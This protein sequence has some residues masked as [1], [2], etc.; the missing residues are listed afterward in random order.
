[1]GAILLAGVA[2]NAE[3]PAAAPLTVEYYYKLAPGA[4]KEWLAL[5]KKNHHPILREHM[6]SGLL[7]S[8]KLYERRYHSL[9]PAWDYK[10]V[11]VWRDSAAHELAGQR[12]AEITRS[13]YPNAAEHQAQEKRRWEMTEAHW[14]DV[15]K[16]APLD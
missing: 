2:A 12:E 4:A 9:A 3:Q 10:V 11:M 15:L 8:E 7:L 6:K 1:M 14:D 5:Y 16:D 13:L